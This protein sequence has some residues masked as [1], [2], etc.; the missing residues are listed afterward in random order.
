VFVSHS[1]DDLDWRRKFTQMLAP[2]VRNR[3]LELRAYFC[4]TRGSTPP[5]VREHR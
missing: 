2:L 5:G 1:H 4:G 3:G